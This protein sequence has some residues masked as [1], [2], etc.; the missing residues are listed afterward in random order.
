M[1]PLVS[2]PYPVKVGLRPVLPV[3]LRFALENQLDMYGQTVA[4]QVHVPLTKI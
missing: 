2:A 1:R 4:E 3:P